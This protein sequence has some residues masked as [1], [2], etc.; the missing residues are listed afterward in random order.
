LLPSDKR[1]RLSF[2]IRPIRRYTVLENFLFY[3]T[4]KDLLCLDGR[5]R[6]VELQEELLVLVRYLFELLNPLRVVHRGHRLE[7][8]II[9]P[10]MVGRLDK[11][12][13]GRLQTSMASISILSHVKV[14]LNDYMGTLVFDRGG[15]LRALVDGVHTLGVVVRC[16]THRCVAEQ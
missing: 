9:E 5:L 12:L 14:F 11:P 7:G 15:S 3:V 10:R 4:F 8:R 1:V 6:V 16:L 2:A 13:L